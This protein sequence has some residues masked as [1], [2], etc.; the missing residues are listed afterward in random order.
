MF[1]CR[2]LI[3]I[4]R[5]T[6]Q[7]SIPWLH[8]RN[9][10]WSLFPRSEFRVTGEMIY[11][12]CVEVN[13]SILRDQPHFKMFLGKSDVLGQSF[14]RIIKTFWNY[15]KKLFIGVAQGVNKLNPSRPMFSENR[16]KIKI[17]LNFYFQTSLWCLKRFYEG[18]TTKKS[19]NK[20]LS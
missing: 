12:A 8:L 3:C 9:Y 15:K 5:Y 4:C 18:L 14:I 17:N 10:F 13:G 11:Y 20:T 7:P 19:E 6:Y 2:C 16:I 1:H